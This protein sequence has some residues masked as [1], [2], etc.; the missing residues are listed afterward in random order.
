[1]SAVSA[2]D[3]F[4]FDLQGF[5]VLRGAL[6]QEECT[7][8]LEALQRLE[9]Q[10]Y[11]DRWLETLGPGPPGRPTRETSLPNQLRLNGLPR[12]DPIFDGLIDPP[13]VLPYL[14]EFV[15]LPQLINTWSISK[16]RGAEPGGWHRGVPTTDYSFRNGEI[17]SRMLNVVYFLTDNGPEDGCVVAL[18]G[19]HKS[20]FDLKWGDYDGLEMPGAVPVTGNAGDVLMF[21]EAVLHNGLPKTT[22]GLRTNLYYNYVHAHYNVM[23]REPR[24]CHHF[25]FPPAIRE[26]F[27]PTRRE[28]TAWMELARWDY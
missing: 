15:G 7:A 16:V 8:Y 26:R 5:L 10:R 13:R 28:L 27:P 25:Y 6:S 18:P 22:E 14:R 20:S 12:L 1:M 24:N 4:L 19:S 3:R 11:E 21:S 2:E 23:T 17:R 9:D